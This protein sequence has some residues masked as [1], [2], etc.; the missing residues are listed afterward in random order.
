[1]AIMYLSW[2]SGMHNGK[3][4]QS[5]PYPLLI[6]MSNWIV[7][8]FG[9]SSVA[10]AEHWQTIAD[11]VSDHIQNDVRPVLVLSALKNVSN[12]LEAML[13]QAL[14]GVYPN[15]ISHLK[16]LHL[17]FA[18]QLGLSIHSELDPIFEI[19]EKQ[20]EAN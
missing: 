8:K 14:A 18:T 15:A 19:L 13:H 5:K 9:G 20:C 11:Q 6:S 10:E 4:G 12:L 3:I 7:L 1:M 2:P 17:G 16:E